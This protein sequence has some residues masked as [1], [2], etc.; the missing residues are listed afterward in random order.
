MDHSTWI[1]SVVLLRVQEIRLASR[2][3]LEAPCRGRSLCLVGHD[4]GMAV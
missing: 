4:G 1:G 3:V 2:P